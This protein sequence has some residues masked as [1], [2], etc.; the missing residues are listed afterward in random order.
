MEHAIKRFKAQH[1]RF[2]DQLALDVFVPKEQTSMVAYS[3]ALICIFWLF[4]LI[5]LKKP[6][7]DVSNRSTLM[8]KEQLEFK[9]YTCVRLAK[10]AK[11]IRSFVFHTSRLW[12]FTPLRFITVS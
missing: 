8:R 6:H 10:F 3:G 9:A 12:Q 2:V 5:K 7:I 4:L 11:R 1:R